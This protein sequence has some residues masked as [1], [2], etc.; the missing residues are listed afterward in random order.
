[1]YVKYYGMIQIGL[2]KAKSNL[3]L[4]LGQ[5]LKDQV[6]LLLQERFI[7][8]RKIILGQTDYLKL[9]F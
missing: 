2:T 4:G 8:H 5:L 1:M 6:Y 7:C 9:N 3:L